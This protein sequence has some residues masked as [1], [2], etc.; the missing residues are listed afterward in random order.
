MAEVS[1]AK[2]PW[3]EYWLWGRIGCFGIA[4]E[5]K[6]HEE[7][8]NWLELPVTRQRRFAPAGCTNIRALMHTGIPG[9]PGLLADGGRSTEYGYA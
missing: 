7:N 8:P 3:E 4:P 2:L 9:V 1:S 5:C 6:G